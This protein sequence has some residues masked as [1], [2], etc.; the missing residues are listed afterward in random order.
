R[1]MIDF[2]EEEYKVKNYLLSKIDGKFLE[3]YFHY[4]RT[5][6]T[7]ANNTAVKYM[8]S[9]KTILMPAIRNGAIIQD[10][11][12]QTKFRIKTIY[13]GFL[14]DEEIKS[15]TKVKLS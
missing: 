12:L 8:T 11:Y 2:L 3:K 14:T 4:L 10:P 9:L 13:I 15:L 5:I 6:R 1:Y 7:I